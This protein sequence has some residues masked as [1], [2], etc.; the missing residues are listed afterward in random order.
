[1][2]EKLVC[3]AC[4]YAGEANKKARGNG[5]VEFLLW[6]FFLIPGIIYSIWSRGGNGKNACQKCGSENMIPQDTPFGQKLISEHHQALGMTREQ[7]ESQ[8]ANGGHNRKVVLISL[9]ILLSIFFVIIISVSGGA[10]K[11]NIQSAQPA[12]QQTSSV[13][14]SNVKYKELTSYDKAGKTWRNIAIPSGTSQKDLI[15]LAKELHA[16][17]TKSYFHIFDDEA[18]FKEFMDWDIN[19]GKVRDKDGKA[20]QIE[21]CSDIAYCRTL[22]QQ[23]KDA[24]PFPEAWATKH[25]IAIINEM[26]DTNSGNPK[27]KLSSPLGEEMSSL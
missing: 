19:Y 22:V 8:K 25:K 13:P 26:M 12:L 16:K 15:A 18:K 9:L 21:Q 23:G 27:W 20:K 2:T 10:G 14:T 24:F 6:C 11:E 3:T 17:D 5:L 7:L 1:M 4:G